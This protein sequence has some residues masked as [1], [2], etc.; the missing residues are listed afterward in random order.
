M[1]HYELFYLPSFA[2]NSGSMA[3][4]DLVVQLEFQLGL[5]ALT[6][7]LISDAQPIVCLTQLWIDLDRFCIEL[8][9]LFIIMLGSGKDAELQISVEAF[10]VERDGF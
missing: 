1:N 9:R 5:L 3:L 6:E 10:W 2:L 4:F 8:N 7:P